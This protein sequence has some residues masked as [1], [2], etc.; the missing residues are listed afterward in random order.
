MTSNFDLTKEDCITTINNNK[1]L[2]YIFESRSYPFTSEEK[3]AIAQ[4]KNMLDKKITTLSDQSKIEKM[5]HAKESE[6]LRFYYGVDCNLEAALNAFEAAVDHAVSKENNHV[7]NEEEMLEV[8]SDIPFYSYGKDAKHRPIHIINLLTIKELVDNNKSKDLIKDAYRYFLQKSMKKCLKPGLIENW[9]SIYNFEGL[10]ADLTVEEVKNLIEIFYINPL[11]YTMEYRSYWFNIDPSIRMVIGHEEYFEREEFKVKVVDHKTINLM[12]NHVNREQI[13]K[14]F[15]GLAE[16][17][18]LKET[19]NGNKIKFLSPNND[20]SISKE[21]QSSVYFRNNIMNEDKYEKICKDML[22]KEALKAHCE[23]IVLSEIP[24]I[25][26]SLFR[27]VKE[28]LTKSNVS[29]LNNSKLS[30]HKSRTEIN[31]LIASNTSE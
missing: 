31:P 30:F 9:V 26:L 12:W 24:R 3:S 20:Y 1:T 10:G 23:F 21:Q 8:L 28:L 17:L 14:K 4:I 15:Q 25:N 16:D 22:K 18:D 27:N 29:E 19:F 11:Y 2:R 7:D 6:L 5:T 13:E